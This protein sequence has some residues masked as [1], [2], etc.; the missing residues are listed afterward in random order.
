MGNRLW[1]LNGEVVVAAGTSVVGHPA[2]TYSSLHQTIEARAV[3]VLLSIDH[4][5]VVNTR[6]G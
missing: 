2:L 6:A 3:C 1:I 4:L 5:D